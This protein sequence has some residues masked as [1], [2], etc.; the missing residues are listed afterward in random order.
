MKNKWKLCESKT[1][2]KVIIIVI[3][4]VALFSIVY[5]AHR[6][7]MNALCKFTKAVGMVVNGGASYE[8]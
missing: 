5:F 4:C 6:Y 8:G 3:I 2:L 7:A 1:P